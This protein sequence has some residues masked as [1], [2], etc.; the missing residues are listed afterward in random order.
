MS[1]IVKGVLEEELKRLIVLKDNYQ[2]R[3]KKYPPGYLLKRKM[4][5]RVYYYLSF[6]EGSKIKQKYLGILKPEQVKSYKELIKRKR[7][8]QSQLS[9]VKKN[10]EYLKRLLKK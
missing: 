7:E 2:A 8:L 1:K 6:R 4:K 5:R 3:M 9:D 10:I